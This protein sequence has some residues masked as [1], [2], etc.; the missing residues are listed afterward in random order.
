MWEAEINVC[1]MN[2]GMVP[3]FFFLASTPNPT[4]SWQHSTF[5]SLFLFFFLINFLPVTPEGY[6]L[7][8]NI[9]D[10]VPKVSKIKDLCH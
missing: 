9:L 1:S 10:M 3:F 4:P 2:E 7:W 8:S 6:S 5:P